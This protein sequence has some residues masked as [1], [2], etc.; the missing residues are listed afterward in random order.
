[1]ARKSRKTDTVQLATPTP[2]MQKYNTA[3][4]IRLSVMDFGRNDSESVVNQEE[5][6]RSYVDEHPDLIFRDIY[7]DNGETGTNFDRPKWLNLMRECRQGNINCIIIKD[8][9]RLGRNYIETG[10]YLESI[11]PMLGVRLIAVNDRYDSLNLSNGERLVSNIKNLVND[12]Y[13][14]DISRKVIAAMHTK[15]KNG[16]FLGGFASYGYLIDPMDRRKI[17]VNPDTAPIV[18]RI[19]E[20]KAENMGNGTICQVLN[21]ENIPC[22]QKYRYIKGFTQSDKYANCVWGVSTVADII[23]NPLY[24][25]HMTQG[26]ARRALC[27]GKPQR[28]TKRDEWFIVHNTHEPIVTEELYD[29]ANAAFDERAEKYKRNRYKNGN[30]PHDRQEPL[31]NGVAYCADC[32]IGLTRKKQTSS[33]SNKVAWV[34]RCKRHF[35][36][37]A[38]TK[39]SIHE[40]NL[41][42]SVYY[43]I[44]TQIQQYVDVAEILEKL[45][46]DNGYKSRLMRYEEEIEEIEK[47]LRR[48]SSLRQAIYE[49]YAAKLLTASEYQYAIDKYNTDMDKQHTKLDAMKAERAEYSKQT[50]QTNKWLATFEQFMDNKALNREMVQ[51]LVER[52]EVSNLDKVSVSFKFRDELESLIAEVEA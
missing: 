9:S 2:T 50:K 10:E 43:A 11:L 47:E 18:R 12:I 48:L 38:C 29:Q 20:M 15:Q 22:P 5:L 17:V 36:V 41:Y 27:D 44:R 46:R 31:L 39:K 32:G 21:G 35:D 13:T 33:G 4:Y 25:G 1:M 3:L 52:V 7:T 8:L 24:L 30:A 19:F 34:F 6:L 37:Q 28:K 51:A 23:R 45:N 42:E 26:K 40:T 16:E 14:K 49:D